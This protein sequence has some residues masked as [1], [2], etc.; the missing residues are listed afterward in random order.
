MFMI[1]GGYAEAG[2]RVQT[3]RGPLSRDS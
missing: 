3:R 2:M 1:F